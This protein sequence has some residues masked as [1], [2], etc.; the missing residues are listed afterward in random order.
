[1]MFDVFWKFLIDSNGIKSEEDQSEHTPNMTY[2]VSYLK[3]ELVDKKIRACSMENNE[4]QPERCQN[5]KKKGNTKL[6]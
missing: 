2:V 4:L 6:W 1:M 3:S 5:E